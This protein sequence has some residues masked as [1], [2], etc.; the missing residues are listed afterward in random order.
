MTE[1]EDVNQVFVFLGQE[2]SERL[3]YLD[4]RFRTFLYN[5]VLVQRVLRPRALIPAT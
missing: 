3:W 1:R 2:K 5:V 4:V